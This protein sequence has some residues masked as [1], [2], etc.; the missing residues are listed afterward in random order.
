MLKISLL[1]GKLIFFENLLTKEKIWCIICIST[2][3][4]DNRNGGIK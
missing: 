4:T 3:N 1:S 2:D